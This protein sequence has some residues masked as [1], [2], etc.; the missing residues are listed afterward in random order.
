MREYS[1][2]FKNYRC[3]EDVAPAQFR[4][5]PGL[6][7]FVGPNNGG[8]TTALKSLYELKGVLALTGDWNSIQRSIPGQ[9]NT[10][11]I[12]GGGDSTDIFTNPHDRALTVEVEVSDPSASEISRWVLKGVRPSGQVWMGEA[13]VGPDGHKIVQHIGESNYSLANGKTVTVDIRPWSELTALVSELRYV[14]SFRHALSVSGGITDALPIGTD[15]IREWSSWQG[16]NNRQN[17]IRAQNVM[18]DVARL[19]GY[20]SLNIAVTPDQQDLMITADDRPLRL[21]ELGG[22]IAHFLIVLGVLTMH[23][24]SM[25]LIDEPEL[26]LHP[27]LQAEFLMNIAERTKMHAVIFSTH[28]LGL[29]RSTAQRIY[30]L[31]RQEGR[32][33]MRQFEATNDLPEFLGEMSF[34]AYRELG[35]E[36][37]LLVEGVNDVLAV[38][39]FLKALAKEHLILVL[40]M[41]GNDL[42]HNRTAELSELQRLGV[43]VGVLIDSER[44]ASGA[45]LELRREKFIAECKRL[46]FSAHA[47]ERRAIENYLTDVAVKAEFGPTCRGLSDYEP[48]PAGATGWAKTDNWRAASRMTRDDFVNT[49]LGKFL[50]GL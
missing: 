41:N 15:F 18:R 32:S 35:C 40:P 5:G 50:D 10:A 20:K 2:T 11:A 1:I 45:P 36:R 7:A 14:G 31:R 6:T 34:T 9:Q 23:P 22:G 38:R 8:K 46:G 48:R 33:R 42:M 17:N 25:V 39:Q 27:A 21:R 16:G 49:D 47:T 29:A 4:F 30:S 24:S 28:S 12:P 37:V 44:S 13:Y 3:F 43:P 19:F 26:N